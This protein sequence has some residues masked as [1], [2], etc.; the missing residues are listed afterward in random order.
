M[1]LPFFLLFLLSSH[2]AVDAFK[3]SFDTH[4]YY[5]LQHDP[6]VGPSLSQV[7]ARLG[8]QVVERA[9]ELNNFWVVRIPKQLTSTSHDKRDGSDDP[10]F[11]ALAALRTP[12]SARDPDLLVARSIADSV[13]HLSRQ[14]L[15]QRVKRAPPPVLPGQGDDD[16][17]AHPLAQAVVER[18]GIHDP[19]FI[20]Q[21]HLVNDEFPEHS[22][23]VS[24]LW[25]MGIT[26]A[27]VVTAL[28]DDGLDYESEDLADNF[29]SAASSH[30]FFSP[31]LVVAVCLSLRCS[32]RCVRSGPPV[33]TIIMTTKTSP[34]RSFPTTTTARVVRAKSAQ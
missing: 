17:S 5:V 12:L 33:R 1:R 22:M 30:L 11:A 9:G 20:R 24:Q 6:H 21:W 26:G 3:C 28:V 32:P 14:E 25:E 7:A 18:L 2:H 4:D 16:P 13:K 19:Q 15:R 8:V 29:V 27:G 10:V 34:R 31:S 23:N